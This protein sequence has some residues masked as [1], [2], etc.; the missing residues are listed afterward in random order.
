MYFKLRYIFFFASQNN[1]LCLRVHAVVISTL[2]TKGHLYRIIGIVYEKE[3]KSALVTVE[4]LINYVF[5][6]LIFICILFLKC[7][8]I[9]SVNV[10]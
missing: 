2:K 4:N 8:H 9:S 1:I 5:V 10:H 7:T 6:G 3:L